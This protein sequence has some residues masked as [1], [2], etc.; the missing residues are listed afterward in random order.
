MVG[1]GGMAAESFVAIMAMIAACTL[2]PGAYFAVNSPAG[3][4]GASP[5]D[6]TA[7]DFLVEFS[8]HRS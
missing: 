8:H 5:A 1:Y 3:I 4:V 6:A 7:D 2:T